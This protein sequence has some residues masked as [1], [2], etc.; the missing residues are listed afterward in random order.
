VFVVD[1]VKRAFEKAKVKNVLFTP[2]DEVERM[3]L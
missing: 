3:K 1:E 2:L